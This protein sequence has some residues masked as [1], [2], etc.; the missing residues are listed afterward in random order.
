MEQVEGR[1]Q[2]IFCCGARDETVRLDLEERSDK[3]RRTGT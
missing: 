3:R 2:Q 1:L